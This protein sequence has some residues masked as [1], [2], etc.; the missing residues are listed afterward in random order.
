MKAWMSSNFGRI[1]PLTSELIALE[2][3]KICHIILFLISARLDHD[4]GVSNT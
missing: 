1:P 2:R 4:C 3:L